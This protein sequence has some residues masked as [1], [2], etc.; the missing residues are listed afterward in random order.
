SMGEQEVSIIVTNEY[1]LQVYDRIHSLSPGKNDIQVHFS[2]IS[3]GIYFYR[4]QSSEGVY[5]GKFIVQ[6]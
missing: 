4:I 5:S 1:G 2:K 3:N 6:K